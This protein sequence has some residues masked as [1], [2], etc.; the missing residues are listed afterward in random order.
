MSNDNIGPRNLW[1]ILIA[2][3]ILLILIPL[4]YPLFL[5]Y[6]G[7]NHMQGMAFMM[8]WGAIYFIILVLVITLVIVMAVTYISKPST[9]PKITRTRRNNGGNGLKELMRVLTHEEKTVLN[10]LIKNG[11]EMLQKDISRGLG[12]TR[13]KTHRILERM[14]ERNLVKRVRIGNTNKVILEDWILDYVD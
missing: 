7:V 12:F 11:G 3:I 8:G 4:L 6:M 9:S 13:V 10:L 5:P 2:L 1:M 14:A